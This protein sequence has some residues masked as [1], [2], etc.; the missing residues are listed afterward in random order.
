MKAILVLEM[1]SSCLQCEFSI[2][3][4]FTCFCIVNSMEC[5]TVKRPDWCPL[6]PMPEKKDEMKACVNSQYSY[7][8]GYN[9]CIDEILGYKE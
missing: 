8:V 5:S 9:A 3:D 4:D 7:A 1:P 2:D 6:K